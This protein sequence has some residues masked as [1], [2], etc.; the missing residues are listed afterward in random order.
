VP[1]A[2]VIAVVGVALAAWAAVADRAVGMSWAATVVDCVVGL[3][4]VAAAVASGRRPLPMLGLASVGF[5]W[6]VASTV[7]AATSV[8]RGLLVL[9][10][11]LWSEPRRPSGWRHAV[12]YTAAIA[13]ALGLGGQ[14]G[15][16]GLLVAAAVF[17]ALR[18]EGHRVE[19]WSSITSVGV[20]GLVLAGSW[21]WSRTDPQGFHPEV[22]LTAYQ[23]S[24]VVTAGTVVVVRRRH[25]ASREHELQ[26]ALASVTDSG[27][28]TFVELLRR[29]VGDATLEVL[30]AGDRTADPASP[31]GATRTLPVTGTDGTPLCVVTY[32]TSA[33]ADPVTAARVVTATRLAVEHVRLTDE[34][35]AQLA[36]VEASRARLLTATD[37]ERATAAA[38]LHDTVDPL[39]TRA[40]RAIESG[41]SHTHN[42]APSVGPA[43]AAAQELSTTAEEL[44]G[45]VAGVAP[46]PLGG[47]RLVE[48]L[49]ALSVHS[50]IEVVVRADGDV[51]ADPEEEAA[52]YFVCSEALANAHKHSRA[53]RV[54]VTLR[55]QQDAMQVEVADNGVGDADPAG[56]GLT[57]LADRLA[58]LGGRL[59]VA[60]ERN[61]GT[62]VT[63]SVPAHSVTGSSSTVGAGT[64]GSVPRRAAG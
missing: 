10:L 62:I 55:A 30:D 60:S 53:T 1:T 11:L 26:A 33:L 29:A 47:G 63:A 54:F 15:A 16:A 46:F 42:V 34:L 5:A 45:L 17:V 59:H 39:L 44:E 58:V 52:L 21:V 12:L 51:R 40:R 23:V 9:A 36:E 4:F 27:M 22:A 25:R 37:L 61:S 7:D 41:L 13:V 38:E 2:A 24:L 6:L 64:G 49:S 20:V 32:R 56:A 57:A 50:P 48:A 3:A 14:L 18:S 8:H 28:S 43:M 35:A 31:G 19:G